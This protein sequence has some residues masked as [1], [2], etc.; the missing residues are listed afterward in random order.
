MVIGS[1]ELWLKEGV[2]RAGLRL[3]LLPVLKEGEWL[4][5]SGEMAAVSCLNRDSI[6]SN[7]ESCFLAKL[8]KRW[9]KIATF[10]LVLSRSLVKAAMDAFRPGRVIS[11]TC[12][13]SS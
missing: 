3:T 11:L 2:G 13:I 12:L 4:D 6:E 5:V 8:S 9:S 7:R 1:I 10:F